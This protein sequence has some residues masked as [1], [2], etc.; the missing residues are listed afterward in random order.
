MLPGSAPT[1]FAAAIVDG[2][3]GNTKILLHF[4]GS[5]TDTAKGATA[6]TV[7]P[8]GSASNTGLAYFGSNGVYL[9]EVANSFLTIS[10]TTDLQPGGGDFTIDFWAKWIGT[11]GTSKLFLGSND[12]TA[13]S[14]PYQLRVVTGFMYFYASVDGATW[15]TFNGFS[16]GQTTYNTWQHWAVIRNNA[17]ATANWRFYRDGVQTA[18]FNR[19]SVSL[20]SSANPLRL[21]GVTT[22]V[23]SYVDEFR[24]SDIARWTT[25]FTPPTRAYSP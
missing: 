23:G 2:N 21:G 8:S 10:P 13:G 6:H 15:D 5:W 25:A 12:A 19:T 9:P 16:M 3:D 1:L 4:N 17:D 11:T 24:Y 22:G 14:F 20:V 7:T 18:Q